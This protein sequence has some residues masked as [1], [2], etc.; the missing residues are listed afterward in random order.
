[1]L[2][3]LLFDLFLFIDSSDIC[4][5][6]VGNTLFKCCDNLDDAK[7][8]IESGCRLVTSWFKIYSLK[9]NPDKCHVM[10]FGAKTLPEDFIIL[11]DDT[12][13]FVEDQV[14]YWVLH[15]IID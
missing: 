7:S 2:G 10:V 1:M 4:N 15:L 13:L 11:V 9:M 3:P 5:F 12:A 8:S 6:A 14:R